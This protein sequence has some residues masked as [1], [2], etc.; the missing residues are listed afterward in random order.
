MVSQMYLLNKANASD[1][2][3]PFLNIHLSISNGFD[4]S[5]IYKKLGDFDFDKVIFP[6]W[7][8]MFPVVPLM[9]Y[10]FSQ[11]IRFARASSHVTD[12]NA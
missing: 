7:I 4:L 10:T 6:F 3:A 8:V 11:I 9:G 5:K 2:D 12:F 1:T